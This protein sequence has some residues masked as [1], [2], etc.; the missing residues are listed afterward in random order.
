MDKLN[1]YAIYFATTIVTIA[2]FGLI[3]SFIFK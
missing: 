2:T 1:E 3:I